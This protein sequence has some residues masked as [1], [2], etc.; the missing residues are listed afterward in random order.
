MK[1]LIRGEKLEITEPIR[2]YIEEKLGKLDR[3]L[4]NSDEITA[5]VNAKVRGSGGQKIEVTIPTKHITLRAEESHNDLYAAIDLV[6][7]KLEVQIKK[8]KSKMQTLHKKHAQ[9]NVFAYDNIEDGHEEEQQIVK[10]K[11]VHNKPMGEEEA[12]LQMELLHHDFFVF[13]NTDEDCTS[14]VYKR[15]DGHFGI[16][17]VR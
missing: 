10:R 1:F 4:E 8:N 9:E 16:L 17:N 2:E 7:E 3:F 15:K 14:I 13:K 6:Q 11:D 5:H 12:I